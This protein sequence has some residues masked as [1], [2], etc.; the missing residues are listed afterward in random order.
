MQMKITFP[1]GLRVNAQLGEQ[2]IATDQGVTS[3]GEGSAP[4]PFTLFMASIGT[5]AGLYVLSFCKNHGLPT[6]G[7]YLTQ[8]MHYDHTERRMAKIDLKVHVPAD[9]PEKY[10]R[11]LEKSAELCAVKRALV[12]PPEI[13]VNTVAD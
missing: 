12:N 13:T 1:G 7:V 8:E 10:H 9:F 5:C 11:A 4:E 3:G 2:V 6:E